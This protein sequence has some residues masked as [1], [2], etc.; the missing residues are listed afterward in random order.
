LLVQ[1]LA[2]VPLGSQQ[3]AEGSVNFSAK[4]DAESQTADDR[5]EIELI[6][7]LPVEDERRSKHNLIALDFDLS[8]PAGRERRVARFESAGYQRIRCIDG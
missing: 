3:T 2:L 4:S 6:D 5:L 7:I 1:A 8:Q